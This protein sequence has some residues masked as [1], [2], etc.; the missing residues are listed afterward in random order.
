[1]IT[2][3]F[4]KEQLIKLQTNYGKE[5]FDLSKDMFNLWYEMFAD[6]EEEGL[7]IAVSNCIKESEFAPNIAGLM[8]FYRELETGRLE[9]AETMN[10]KYTNI[11]SYWGEKYD[12]DTFKAIVEYIFRFPKEQRKVQMK[13]LT[14]NAIRF[15]IDCRRCGRQDIPTIKEYVEGK[16]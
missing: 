2:Q 10:S 11:R 13:E 14:H 4:L 1:M 5:K 12:H 3:K 16:R 8:K 9:I 7:R 6:C 15:Y